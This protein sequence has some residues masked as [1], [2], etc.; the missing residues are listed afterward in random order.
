[1]RDEPRRW[2]WSASVVLMVVIGV[3]F[4]LEQFLAPGFAYRWLALSKDGLLGGK[5][6]QLLT[7]QFLHANIWHL[8]GNLL[9][10]W[11]FGRYIEMRLGA[12]NF[13]KLYFIGGLAGGLLQSLLGLAFEDRFGGPVIGASAGVV[14]LFAAFARLEPNAEVLLWFVLP[15]KARHV[16]IFS[17]VVAVVFMVLPTSGGIAHAAHLGGLLAGVIYIHGEFYRRPLFARTR[18]ATRARSRQPEFAKTASAS[19]SYWVTPHAPANEPEA[20]PPEEFISREVDPILDKISAHGIQ[21]LT[22]RE[23]KIL[24][25][26]R[27]QMER[28]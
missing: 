24:E 13:L 25:S 23:R 19:G 15:V 28:R 6:W 2:H 22:T 1:M 9:G 10:L 20:V 18:A 26:A 27:K 16:L 21:S 5:L 7:F 12:A 3:A 8:A 4:V 14:A 11:F 17:L